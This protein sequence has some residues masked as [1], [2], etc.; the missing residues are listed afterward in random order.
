M[1]NS[2]TKC[3]EC[4]ASP[5]RLHA[6]GCT[7]GQSLTL[8]ERVVALEAQV[9]YLNLELVM[10]TSKNICL[11]G[12]PRELHKPASYCR[13]EELLKITCHCIGYAPP[14]PTLTVPAL[15]GAP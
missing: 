14:D 12:H 5:L 11:C 9:K 3:P 2:D 13:A 4:G 8:E 7:R 6:P 10:R 15:F 1:P